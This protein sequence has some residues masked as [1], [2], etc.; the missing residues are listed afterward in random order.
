MYFPETGRAFHHFTIYTGS[1]TDKYIRNVSNSNIDLVL[2]NR[3]Y[4]GQL[5]I[6][7]CSKTKPSQSQEKMRFPVDLINLNSLGKDGTLVS[8]ILVYH[9]HKYFYFKRSDQ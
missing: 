9:S 7:F 5:H 6:L 8:M 4:S 1:G 3:Q 2:Y